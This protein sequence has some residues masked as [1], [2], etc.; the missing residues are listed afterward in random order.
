[1]FARGIFPVIDNKANKERYRM[2]KTKL[3]PLI[4]VILVT[5]I[6]TGGC[7]PPATPV[8]SQVP[9]STPA[10]APELPEPSVVSGKQG[11]DMSDFGK[12]SLTTDQ[13]EVS[14][15]FKDWGKELLLTESGFW[16]V[17]VPKETNESWIIIDLQSKKQL[18]ALSIKPRPDL[19]EHLWNGDTAVLEG[20][21]DKQTWTALVILE[22][23]HEELNAQEWITFILPEDMGAYRYFR[24]FIYDP[25]FISMAGLRLYK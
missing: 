2:M 12:I 23:N 10:P 8:P 14:N 6:I 22:L 19:L 3:I 13:L 16:H 7:A 1:L 25:G 20:S 15:T 4:I 18:S 24:L 5:G 11:V 21:D 9:T 17:P